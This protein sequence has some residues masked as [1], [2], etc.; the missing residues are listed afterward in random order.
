[1]DCLF[2]LLRLLSQLWLLTIAG[3]LHFTPEVTIR[4]PSSISFSFL[5]DFDH[6]HPGQAPNP[7]L[8]PVSHTCSPEEAGDSSLESSKQ[9]GHLYTEESHVILCSGDWRQGTWPHHLILECQCQGDTKRAR[10]SITEEQN[11]GDSWLR[12][13]LPAGDITLAP[14]KRLWRGSLPFRHARAREPDEHPQVKGLKVGSWQSR[15]ADLE[16]NRKMWGGGGVQSGGHE[17]SHIIA[18][19]VAYS[20]ALLLLSSWGGQQGLGI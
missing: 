7:Q 10:K 15:S 11:P 4:L 3:L 12:D 13:W 18:R 8:G 1:M 19:K 16:D 5:T 9:Q 6:T 20:M 14:A 2:F 17:R